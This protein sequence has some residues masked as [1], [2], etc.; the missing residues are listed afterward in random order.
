MI[1]VAVPPGCP[2]GFVDVPMLA[3]ATDVFSSPGVS[4]YLTAS[5]PADVA[6]FYQTQLPALNWQPTGAPVV[7][8]NLAVVDF[9]RGNEQLRLIVSVGTGGTTVLISL[10]AI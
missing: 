8:D 6:A 5:T 4:S 2:S 3:D 1:V 7:S 9:V 10:T